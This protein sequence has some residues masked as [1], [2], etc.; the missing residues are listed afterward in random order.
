[1]CNTKPVILYTTWYSSLT[2]TGATHAHI[3]T[4]KGLVWCKTCWDFWWSCF[5]TI[6]DLEF[7]ITCLLG[8]GNKLCWTVF[9]RFDNHVLW[10]HN[11][12][13]PISW[14]LTDDIKHARGSPQNRARLC[15][16]FDT[17]RCPVSRCI[18][19]VGVWRFHEDSGQSAH[20]GFCFS[21]YEVLVSLHND[22][23]CDMYWYIKTGF[24]HLPYGEKNHY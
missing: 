19:G 24:K 7:S 6:I 12:Y 3:H 5:N 15:F 17:N 14:W 18:R 1:M 20:A 8:Y 13:L 16:E 11:L 21:N 10:F 9:C 23:Y 2:T 22:N 4:S